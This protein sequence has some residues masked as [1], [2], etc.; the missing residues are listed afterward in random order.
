MIREIGSA[1]IKVADNGNLTYTEDSKIKMVK[2][3]MQSL[4]YII[5]VTGLRPF[6]VVH[7]DMPFADDELHRRIKHNLPLTEDEIE[8]TIF[9]RENSRHNEDDLHIVDKGRTRFSTITYCGHSIIGLS[10]EH[11]YEPRLTRLIWIFAW[12]NTTPRLLRIILLA[13]ASG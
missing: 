9:A 12:S 6:N 5:H 7:A 10:A 8:Y 1:K 13:F 11:V 3:F 4:P 2:E